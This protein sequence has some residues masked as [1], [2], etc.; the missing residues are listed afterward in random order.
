MDPLW[1]G[2]MNWV[3]QNGGWTGQSQISWDPN[4]PIRAGGYDVEIRAQALAQLNEQLVKLNM[5][6]VAEEIEGE[7]E[8]AVNEDLDNLDRQE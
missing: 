1:R 8:G 4:E 7:G 3:H 2:F 5:K 6:P